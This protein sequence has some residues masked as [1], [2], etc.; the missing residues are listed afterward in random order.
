MGYA[1]N[2]E[3]NYLVP[4]LIQTVVEEKGRKT[5]DIADLDFFIGEEAAVKRPNYNVDYPVREGIVANWDNMEKYWQR[6]IYQYLCC[7][8][9]E[10]YFMLVSCYLMLDAG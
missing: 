8:P 9:E 1:G 10:H 3:P 6:C 7:D 5:N 4:S 2:T